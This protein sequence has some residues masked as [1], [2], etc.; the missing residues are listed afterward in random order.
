MGR[1]RE[2]ERYSRQILVPGWNQEKLKRAT[3][4]IVGLGG[5]GSASALYLAGAGIGR[6]R[7]CDC[8]K[9]E[10]S[11]LNR[12]VLYEESSIGSFKVEEAGRR[13][14][15]L[16]PLVELE[17]L[18]VF[19]DSHTVGELVKGCQV[20]LDGLDNL[21]SRFILNQ[22]SFKKRIPYIYGA[23]HGWLGYAGFFHP[24]QTGCLACLMQPGLSQPEPVPVFGTVPGMI[25]LV[26]A[27][28]A[29]KWIQGIAPSLLGRLLI[30]DGLHLTFDLVNVDKNPACPLCS[31]K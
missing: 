12:Q 3:A 24:P 28:E 15:A 29:I 5:L 23:V 10:R 2:S 1:E 9:V 19:L 13:L 7:L 21:E 30:Y 8:D 31:K 26:Q 17:K 25:G 20:I 16:N 4:L 27:T 6:L 18:N 22:E 14:A 11:D